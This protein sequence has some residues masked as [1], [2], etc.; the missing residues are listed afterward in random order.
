MKSSPYGKSVELVQTIHSFDFKSHTHA[1]IQR[2]ANNCKE[3]SKCHLAPRT[4]SS[5]CCSTA[6]TFMCVHVGLHIYI[7]TQPLRGFLQDGIS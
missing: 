3:P 4:K 5:R 2:R 7:H 6:I 1:S